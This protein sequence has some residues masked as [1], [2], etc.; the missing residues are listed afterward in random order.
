MPVIVRMD[1]I[2]LHEMWEARAAVGRWLA[3]IRDQEAFQP[4]YYPG[5]LLTEKYPH[6]A[7]LREARRAAQ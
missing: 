1:D 5:S 6:L 3:K 7:E 4:T 2:N